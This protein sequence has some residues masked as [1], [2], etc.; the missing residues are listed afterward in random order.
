MELDFLLR[1]AKVCIDTTSAEVSM[2]EWL[3]GAKGKEFKHHLTGELYEQ[4]DSRGRE[5]WASEE[6]IELAQQLSNKLEAQSSHSL[7]AFFAT[8]AQSRAEEHGATSQLQEQHQDH[9]QE[10]EQQLQQ[11]QAQVRK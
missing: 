6:K 11:E 7:V 10:Q 9:D 2:D 3:L 8:D 1:Y 5:G 4:K